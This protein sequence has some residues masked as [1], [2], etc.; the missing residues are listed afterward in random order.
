MGF[1]FPG[2][3]RDMKAIIEF[4]FDGSNVRTVEAD[5]EHLFV[6]KDICQILEVKNSSQALMHLDD[7]EK[8]GGIL[9]D[10]PWKT[11]GNC[12]CK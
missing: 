10:P 1:R 11:T 8:M 7:D 3:N 5:G 2:V 9:N 4:N 6:A 12:C